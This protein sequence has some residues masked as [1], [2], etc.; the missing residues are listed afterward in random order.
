MKARVH[1][2]QVLVIDMERMSD[3]DVATTLE[4]CRY[5]NPSVLS[6]RSVEVDWS[7]EHP[8]NHGNTQAQAVADLFPSPQ[9][10]IEPK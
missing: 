3:R 9:T 4:N 5:V 10:G 1:L 8:L 6:Q 7:D 2:M